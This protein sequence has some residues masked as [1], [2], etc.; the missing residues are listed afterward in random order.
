M[1]LLL[2]PGE[3]ANTVDSLRFGSLQQFWRVSTFCQRV[4]ETCSSGHRLQYRIHT[5]A[6]ALSKCPLHLAPALVSESTSVSNRDLAR[7]HSDLSSKTRRNAKFRVVQPELR[8]LRL[9]RGT[10]PMWPMQGGL[11]LLVQAFKRPQSGCFRFMSC[12]LG[13]SDQTRRNPGWGA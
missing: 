3:T 7:G 4:L 9:F 11:A 8:P 10:P 5:R 2:K 13:S 1:L 12:V 6:Q